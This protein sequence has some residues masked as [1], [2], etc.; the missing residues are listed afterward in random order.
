M[1]GVLLVGLLLGA[2]PAPALADPVEPPA[3]A[4]ACVLADKRLAEL[5]GLAADGERW[6]AVN[7]GGTKSTVYVLTRACKV[8]RTISGPT[9]PYDV[10]DLARS[11]DGT[12]WLS[13]TGDNDKKRA[14]V[15]LIALTPDGKTTLYRLTYPDGPHDTEALLLDRAD[16][17]HLITKNPLGTADIYRPVGPL[18]SPGPTALVH[19]GS[20][21]LTATDTPG[22]PVPAGIGSVL[23]TGAASTADGSVVALRT[24]TEAYLFGVPDGEDL[25]TALGD[26]PIRI[27]LP[28]E[29]QGEAIAFE[30]DG[31]L[32][33][34]S[35][36][37]GQ[38]IRIV[39]GAAALA[40]PPPPA[41]P[42]AEAA[43]P[44]PGN[45]QPGGKDGLP[46]LPAIGIT[47]VVVLGGALLLRRRRAR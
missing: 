19:A 14:T 8:E 44:D 47:V 26:H 2:G 1:L 35:E 4:A 31:S 23:V 39:P 46:T 40:A 9:D 21:R 12:F 6:Y 32:V 24:Y 34:A 43:Q 15:A 17:P 7:D 38:P 25:V 3:P 42:P 33:S 37:I 28:D 22:G 5:S 11:P 45:D 36:G 18:A 30:P 41:P 27:P 20:I 10:E 16:V 29:Q 13:D